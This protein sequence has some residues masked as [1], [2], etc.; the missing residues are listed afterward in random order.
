VLAGSPLVLERQ[1]LALALVGLAAGTALAGRWRPASELP[2][3]AYPILGAL[4]L[5]LLAEDLPRGR[6]A[7]MFLA[8][9]LFGVGLPGVPRL[10]ARNLS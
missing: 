7:T 3:L 10:L 5:K 8:F 2:W 4:A 1:A 9:T 6:P